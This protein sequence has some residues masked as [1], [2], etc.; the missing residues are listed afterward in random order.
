MAVGKRKNLYKLHEESITREMTPCNS[1][2]TP[3]QEIEPKPVAKFVYFP[4]FNSSLCGQIMKGISR[5]GDLTSSGGH[6]LAGCDRRDRCCSP[7][8]LL[9]LLQL[10]RFELPNMKADGG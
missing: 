4:T 7:S 3:K 9:A 8:C 6:V 10:R 2:K 5:I 1:Q